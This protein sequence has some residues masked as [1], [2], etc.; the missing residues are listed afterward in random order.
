LRAEFRTSVT[1]SGGV[2][3]I[4]LYHI[5]NPL[6][7]KELLKIER[8]HP[9][10]RKVMKIG[11]ILSRKG[12]SE[13]Q[14]MFLNG[15][16]G[17]VCCD[18]FWNFMNCMGKKISLSP[19]WTAYRGDMSDGDAFYATWKNFEIIYHVAP[20]LGAEEHRR[21][22]GN[23]VAV[24][25]FQEEGEFD[26]SQIAKLGTV[27]QIFAVVTP[28]ENNYRIATFSNVNIKAYGPS[29]PCE[30]LTPDETKELLLTKLYNGL[31]M[32]TYCPPLNRLFY[33]PR[34]ET[35]EAIVAQFDEE[36]KKEYRKNVLLAFQSEE[37]WYKVKIDLRSTTDEVEKRG[38]VNNINS[39][40]KNCLLRLEP[41]SGAITIIDAKTRELIYSWPIS[42]IAAASSALKTITVEY[43]SERREI[44]FNSPEEKKKCIVQL[45]EISTGSS[46]RLRFEV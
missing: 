39:Y 46:K 14:E 20:M 37:G 28:L 15:Q 34:H 11:V 5:S 19:S 8:N 12:Q 31:M 43:S 40:A 30:P 26:A 16:N 41:G 29:I 1:S 22:I 13:P 36:S 35:L 10:Y 3:N 25:F 2:A 23:D 18:A 4:N 6:F 17:D 24:I 7:N 9:Q 38:L 44:I 27:P 42:A 32:T 45:T 21:L 33:L